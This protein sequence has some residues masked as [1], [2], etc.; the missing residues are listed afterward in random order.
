MGENDGLSWTRFNIR[1]DGGRVI[2]GAIV[3]AA[4]A[5]G[6]QPL[7][8]LQ[9]GA[10]TSK[11]ASFVLAAVEVFARNGFTCM[12]VDAIGHGERDDEYSKPP[13]DENEAMRRRF[14]PEFTTGNVV[15]FR[16]ALDY[17]LSRGQVE[18][19][20]VGFIGSSMGGMLGALFCAVDARVS[21][22][23]LR[24][25][26][27]RIAARRW[28]HAGSAEEAQRLRDAAQKFDSAAFVGFISPRPLLLLNNSDDE[29]ISPEAVSALYEAAGQPKEL[30]WF[31]GGHR[32]NRE[33]HSAEAWLF[34]REA[35]GLK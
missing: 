6:P 22:V 21:A 31:P 17:V 32:D 9:H 10:G 26:G 15:D 20:K 8:M 18:P 33:V 29:A 24:C 23:A 1:S 14:S 16:R 4:E 11:Y 35:M 34:F 12:S 5:S 3:R 13:A 30:R 28:E 27:S 2:P 19:D 7:V 25:S